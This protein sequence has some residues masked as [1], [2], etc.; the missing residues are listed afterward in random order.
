MSEPLLGPNPSPRRRLLS[1]PGIVGRPSGGS[2]V[3]RRIRLAGACARGPPRGSTQTSP[4]LSGGALRCAQHSECHPLRDPP[5]APTIATSEPSRSSALSSSKVSFTGK[6][7]SRGWPRLDTRGDWTS[8]ADTRGE[9]TSCRPT[10]HILAGNPGRA[11]ARF[12]RSRP[13]VDPAAATC[14]APP[15]M[16]RRPHFSSAGD[17]TELDTVRS[18]SY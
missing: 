8:P 4:G 6:T 9:S 7:I 12:R 3:A 1:S 10:A 5:D 17:H 13:Q 14:R 15:V 18:A 2:I 11:G 16:C